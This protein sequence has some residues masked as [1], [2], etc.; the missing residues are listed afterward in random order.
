MNSAFA[1]SLKQ[2]VNLY[3]SDR[4]ISKNA[5]AEMVLKS[6][7]ALSLYLVPYLLML[8]LELTSLPLLFGLW[9]LM[10]FAMG[11]IGT[12]VM[13]DSLH[14]SYSKK[15]QVN[16]IMGISA[17]IIGV[18]PTIWK[19]QHNV[20][21]HSYTNIE[22]ADEDI[23]PRYIL[24]FSPNQPK[25]WFHRYQHIYALFLYTISTLLWITLKDYVKAFQFHKRGL[26]KKDASFPL[27]ILEIFL[28]KMSYFFLFLVIPIYVLPVSTGAVVMM[29]VS[30]H[31]TAGFMLSMIFQ[32]AHVIHTTEFYDPE[33]EVINESWLV[34]QL[35]T[36]TNFGTDNKLLTWFTGGLNHQVE[37][38]LFP[39]ICHIHYRHIA[40]IVQA[41]TAEYNLPYH[42]QKTI[43][44]AVFN[45]F[46]M[47]K[48]LGEGNN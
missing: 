41:T 45:H 37:H 3:F 5:N 17:W 48:K 19:L 42:N 29:F 15:K 43:G 16:V 24:R 22:G 35:K 7:M 39:N 46:R 47:L 14:G 12:S 11:F 18:D 33:D 30:M 9:I 23:D 21:H 38:H 34:H 6:V 13:H 40:K 28:R 26:L 8:W 32:P 44:Q 1:T 36:T 25:R 10:G 4:Q 2:R 31:M 27:F 20:L